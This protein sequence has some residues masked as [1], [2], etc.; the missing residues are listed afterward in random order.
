MTAKII[1]G[2]KIAAEIRADIKKR[3]KSI[4]EKPGL[5]VV[6]VGENPASK[7]YVGMKEKDAKEVGFHSVVKKLKEG[8]DEVDLIAEVSI[9]IA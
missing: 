8:I 7:V 6:I 3:L 9:A 5:A 1:D 4:K 2:K